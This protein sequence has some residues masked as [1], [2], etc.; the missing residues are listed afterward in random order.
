MVQTIFSLF[1]SVIFLS[2]PVVIAWGWVRWARLKNPITLFS[3]LSLIGFVLATASELIAVSMVIYAHV[4]GGFD[5]YD[6]TLM[7]I[8]AWG[9][10][11]S[12]LGLTLAAIGV[13]RPSSLRWHA[14]GC[15]VGTLLYWFVQSA[16]E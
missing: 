4:R 10:L 8:Y 6:P 9:M 2:F 7:K 13:W 1:A 14:L 11:L 15:T 12:F 3:I 16:N 5:Y